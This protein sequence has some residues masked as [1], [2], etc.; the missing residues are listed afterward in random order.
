MKDAAAFIIATIII[1]YTISLCLLL[2]YKPISH[3]PTRKP[4]PRHMPEPDNLAASVQSEMVEEKP[5]VP[6]RSLKPAELSTYFDPDE[7]VSIG[8][9]KLG[10]VKE[11]VKQWT[12][13]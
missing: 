9:R 12:R 13:R 4:R 8:N 1:I 3:R 5:E 7:E 6:G 11:C 10:T 2:V